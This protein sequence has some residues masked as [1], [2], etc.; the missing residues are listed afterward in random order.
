LP[1]SFIGA[2]G[3][4][5]PPGAGGEVGEA[6][7]RGGGRDG[8]R[9][10]ARGS[11]GRGALGRP[12]HPSAAPTAQMP[13]RRC[14]NALHVALRA[15]GGVGAP[16]R[17]TTNARGRPHFFFYSSPALLG[18]AVALVRPPGLPTLALVASAAADRRRARGS[19]VPARAASAASASL[20]AVAAHSRALD[21]SKQLVPYNPDANRSRN[22]GRRLGVAASAAPKAATAKAAAAALPRPPRPPTGSV[23][24]AFAAASRAAAAAAGGTGQGVAR[25]P[26]AAQRAARAAARERARWGLV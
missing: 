6:G 4:A 24:A 11:E 3:G 14:V 20:A 2:G 5:A 7:A 13:S 1:S 15:S 25:S 8:A 17:P 26:D 19:A 18:S 9:R 21:G 22:P 10:A 12:A 16:R 23:N